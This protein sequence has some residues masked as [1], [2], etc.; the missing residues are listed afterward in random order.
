MNNRTFNGLVNA[1]VMISVILLFIEIDALKTADDGRVPLHFITA[2]AAIALLMAVDL[3]VRAREVTRRGQRWLFSAVFWIDVASVLPFIVSLFGPAAWYG[4]LRAM[5]ILRLLKLYHHSSAAQGIMAEL[6]SRHRAIKVVGSITATVALLG[7]V[8]I[9]ELEHAAQPDA[10]GTISDSLW[11]MVVTMTTVGYGDIS[12]QTPGGKLFAGLIMPVSLGI[13]GAVIGI[14]GGAFQDYQEETV[15]EN[16]P[17]S[18][19][20]SA[21]I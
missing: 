9:Y 16:E 12:P 3:V 20:T 4:L 2:E 10:F 17:L 21:H 7:A 11:W 18:P 5:R 15:D 13:M 19:E 8:G 1:A 14:V 6:V